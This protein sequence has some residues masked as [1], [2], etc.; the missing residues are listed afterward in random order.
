M[1]FIQKLKF[2][3]IKNQIE[4]RKKQNPFDVEAAEKYEI[5]DGETNHPNNS[6]YFS[7]HDL[8]GKSILF[9]L[10]KRG[11]RNELWCVYHDVNGNS[12]VN[13]DMLANEE[14]LASVNCIEVGKEWQ[15]QFRGPM[16][17][18][19]NKEAQPIEA[20][21][22]GTFKSTAPI[23]EFSRQSDAAPTAR[24]IAREKLSKS[25][26]KELSENHQVHYEQAGHVTGTFELEG[27]T[28][29]ID[30]RAMRDHSFGKRDWGYMDRHVW[31]MALLETGEV[32]NVNMVRYP[33][34]FELQHGYFE[35]DGKYT[36]V[37]S[38]DEM[39]KISLSGDVPQSI[40]CQIKL[41]DGRILTMTSQKEIEVHFPFDNG[42]YTIFEGISSIEINGV[43]GRGIIEFGY[44][45]DKNRWT[46]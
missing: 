8:T 46:R 24:A 27:Q 33:A 45:C 19:K 18:L 30:I 37:D 9:R 21:L 38:I 34:I 43:K 20:S 40:A 32:L 3:I 22:T 4:K 11:D 41:V 1:T 5:P 7:M 31:L 13:R 39:D 42:I 2:S 29:P 12:Y 36:C 35:K 44:H 6:Y 16:I 25:F 15:F 10:A 23:F 14:S 26:L 28:I 17:N